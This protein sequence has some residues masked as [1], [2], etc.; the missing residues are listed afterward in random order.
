L[1]SLTFL[2]KDFSPKKRQEARNSSKELVSKL[3]KISSLNFLKQKARILE[4]TKLE[5]NVSQYLHK[6][7]SKTSCQE[8]VQLFRFRKSLDAIVNLARK[9]YRRHQIVFKM[10]IL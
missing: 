7:N 10:Y 8:A 4:I 3:I 6:E 2:K 5:L 9:E 1:R